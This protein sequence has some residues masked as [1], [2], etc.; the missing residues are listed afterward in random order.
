MTKF[1]INPE[2]GNPGICNAKVRCRFGGAEEH[3]D[4]KEAARAAFESTREVNENWL[5]GITRQNREDISHASCKACG[6]PVTKLDLAKALHGKK[7]VCTCGG[8]LALSRLKIPVR[9]ESEHLLT[10][11][12][13]K[14]TTFFH[15]TDRR[16]WGASLTGRPT[17]L[18]HIGEHE[19]AV[20]RAVTRYRG[21]RASD[22]HVWAF[23]EVRLKPDAVI[24]KRLTD[25]GRDIA[26]KLDPRTAADYNPYVNRY[27]APGTVSAVV[28]STSLEIVSVRPV[29]AKE[30]YDAP[31]I[32]NLFS[33]LNEPGK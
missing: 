24:G 13:A 1:H 28:P 14:E 7:N 17:R 8:S 10:L 12:A 33:E 20:D 16:G 15:S 2:T 9:P 18:V 22:D 23:Y 5:S 30:I 11:D 3:Y 25:T 19:T 21:R 6:L 26:R 31:S 27:E 4:S 29:R 32:Y